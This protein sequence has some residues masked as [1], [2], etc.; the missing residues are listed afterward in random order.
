MLNFETIKRYYDAG[1]WSAAMVKKAVTKGKLTATEYE[2]I[3]GE[4]YAG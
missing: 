3:T 4:S 2:E 1:V